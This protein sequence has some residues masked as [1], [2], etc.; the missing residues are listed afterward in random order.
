MS[1]RRSFT[2]TIPVHY[3]GTEYATVSTGEGSKT[4]SVHYSGTVYET[5][6][7]NVNVDTDSFEN[8]VDRCNGTVNVLTGSVTATQAAQV[9]SIRENSRK[10]G[11][12]IIQG[13]F[14]TVQS[15]IS[16]QIMEISSRIEATLVH[17]REMAQR[18]IAKQKQMETDYGRLSSRYG[19]IFED[20][21]KELKNRIYELDIP[22]FKFKETSDKT[23]NRGLGTDLASVVAI[24]GA[25][26][27]HLEAM[28]GASV[29][30]RQ[31]MG[32]IGKANTFLVKQKTCEKLLDSCSINESTDAV[33]YA[34]VCYIETKGESEV[35]NSELY[36]SEFI[37][38]PNNRLAEKMKEVT[39]TT[40][41]F[42][43]DML[44]THFSAEVADK[45]AY[46]DSHDERVR[47]YITKLFN[48]T[49]E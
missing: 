23:A 49:L 7:V 33:Y 32:A 11:E 47:D 22:T 14:T 8:S 2:K 12:T 5:V 48:N 28:L 10:V 18:C 21:N 43:Q 29:T 27:G 36:T 26:N 39:F 20:L 13:F 24:S 35:I 31:A 41:E 9:A 19:A 38:K 4:V 1:Y 40:N 46:S 45:Y 6:T 3:S 37:G 30:K 34:P 17:L 25:E 44:K 16:Q 42:D 15:E